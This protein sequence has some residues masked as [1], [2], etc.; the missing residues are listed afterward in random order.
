MSRLQRWDASGIPLLVA[1]LVLG[2]TFVWLGA[3]KAGDP[4]QFL[5]LLRQYELVSE[6]NPML[7]NVFAAVVP[8]LE[9]WCGLLLLLGVAVRGTAVTVLALLT[10]F[11]VAI[12]VRGAALARQGGTPL[13]AVAFDCGCGSGIENVCSKLLQDC[14]LWLLAWVALLSRSR[15]FCLQ[16]RAR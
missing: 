11:L 3:L 6:S 5:K 1:R 2:A 4:V 12:A 10:T 14:A 13:C 7:L 15:R 8:W 9:M 16:R